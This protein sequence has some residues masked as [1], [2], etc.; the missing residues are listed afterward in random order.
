MVEASNA[1]TMDNREVVVSAPGKVSVQRTSRPSPGPGEVLVRTSMV[2]ICGSDVH[3]YQGE[4][5]WITL[6][7]V[8]G[9]EVVGT[10]E[11]VTD[12]VSGFGPGDRV[13]VEPNLACGTC[14]QCRD[15]RYNICERLRV[16]GCQGRG[17]M[18][19]FFTIPANR[20]HH[21][22]DS[23]SDLSAVLVEPLATAVH[24]VRLAG[25]LHGKNVVVLGAGTIGLFTLVAARDAGA[26]S[27][28]STDVAEMKR[29]LA[30]RLGA[31][32][33]LSA[34]S[35]D[36][37]AEVRQLFGGGADVVFDCVSSGASIDQAIRAADKGGTVMVVGV[38]SGPVKV[39]LEL[40]QDQ[41]I[42]V[43]G[44]LMYISEDFQTALDLLASGGVCPDDIVSAAFSLEAAVDAF[45]AAVSGTQTKVVVRTQ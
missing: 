34:D 40:V 11:Q 21:V 22:P 14:R 9:H 39:P 30:E 31:S 36:V 8:P 33:T 45:E 25:N 42:N 17:G 35:E 19:D 24:A 1:M 3:A 37:A 7:Y 20:L 6:P 26:A 29:R 28:V 44:V 5:P 2:G 38:P 4:H 13:V 16:F 12:G 27:V 18:T 41:E 32:K 10:I 43:C 23:M 15:G